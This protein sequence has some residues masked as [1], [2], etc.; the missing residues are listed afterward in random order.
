ML[1]SN[2]TFR[3]LVTIKEASPLRY[4]NKVEVIELAEMCCLEYLFLKMCSSILTQKIEF[5]K[6]AKRNSTPKI[7]EANSKKAVIAENI[8]VGYGNEDVLKN[9]SLTIDEGEIVGLFGE[10]GAGKTTFIK[11]LLGLVPIKSGRFSVFGEDITQKYV[12]LLRST[13]GYVPQKPVNS[14]FPIT[15]REAVAMGRYGKVGIGR[16]LSSDDW[17]VVKKALYQ[18]DMAHHADK[19]LY[20]LSGGQAQR[21][22][23]A[24]AL[25]QEPKMLLLDEPTASLDKESRTELVQQIQQL[26]RTQGMTIIFVSHNP[27]M[28]Q[29]CHR[30]FTFEPE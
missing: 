22:S 6:Q 25:A 1:G 14:H 15:V 10:N 2:V 19:N 7:A 9:V 30:I 5:Q 11:A 4:R 16:R 18:V 20:Q 3:K 8:T 27:K 12:R 17:S 13:L 21:V 23:I 26:N 24:R 29:Y 28:A